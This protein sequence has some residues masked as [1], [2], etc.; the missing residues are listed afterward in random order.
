MNWGGFIATGGVMFFGKEA[1]DKVE[2]MKDRFKK[3]AQ[4]LLD[5]VKG[6]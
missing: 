3:H 5:K 4:E 6:K 2:K 1:P